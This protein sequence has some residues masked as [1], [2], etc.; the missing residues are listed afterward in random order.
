MQTLYRSVMVKRKLSQEAKLSVD[1]SIFV[2]TL[3]YG[4]ELWV[5]TQ[6]TRSQIQ[7]AEMG[8]LHRVAGLSLGDRV[9]SSV[10]WERLKVEPLLLHVEE[11]VEVVQT[12]G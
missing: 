9:R 2:P 4:H 1:W 11:P 6:R 10:I 12:S 5:V 7:E 3:T 8:F